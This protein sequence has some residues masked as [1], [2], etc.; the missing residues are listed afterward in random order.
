MHQIFYW[1]DLSIQGQFLQ[2]D[3]ELEVTSSSMDLLKREEYAMLDS[4]VRENQSMA[5]LKQFKVQ[6]VEMCLILNLEYRYAVLSRGIQ[7]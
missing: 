3:L 6:V 4:Q 7:H 2:K 1:S 5:K